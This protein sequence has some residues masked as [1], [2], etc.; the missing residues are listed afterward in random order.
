M[1]KSGRLAGAA[2]AVALL[3]DPANLHAQ[4]K[5]VAPPPG[6]TTIPALHRGADG[7]IEVVDPTKTEA[8]GGTRE[9]EIVGVA[10]TG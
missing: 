7:K 8:P 3:L 5:P 1:R 10:Y 6:P 9:Y 2:L 4:G